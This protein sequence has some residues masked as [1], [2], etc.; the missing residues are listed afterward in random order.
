M[1][2]EELGLLGALAVLVLFGLIILRG[3]L[4]TAKIDDPFAQYLALGLTSLLGLQA[5]VHM[6][7]VIGLMPTKGLVLPFISYGGSAMVMNLTEAGMLLS[8]SRRRM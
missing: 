6:G 7:V 2:G 5:I 8:L 1:I 3:F 4:L